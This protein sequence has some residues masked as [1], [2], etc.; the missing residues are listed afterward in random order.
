M[1]DDHQEGF[2]IMENTQFSVAEIFQDGCVIQRDKKIKV[3]GTA[4][5]DNTINVSVVK[6]GATIVSGSTSADSEGNYLVVLDPVGAGTGY[7]LHIS[8]LKQHALHAKMTPQPRVMGSF[9]EEE[10]TINDVS[11]GD[12]WLAG[13]QSNME[14]YL[15]YDK[16]WEAT[17]KLPKNPNIHMYNV[18]QRAFEGHNTHNNRG[19][20]GYWFTDSDIEGLGMFSAP[21]YSFAREIQPTIDVPVA[22]IGCNW[23]GSTASAWVPESVLS[24]APLNKYFEEYEEQ[25]PDVSEEELKRLSMEGWS[26]E[27]DLAGWK[28]FEPLMYGR[29]RDWQLKF[30]EASEG[31]EPIPMGPYN[32][33]RPSGLYHTML[34]TLIPYSLKGV[35]WYQGESDCGGRAKTY[36]KL[37]GGLIN[38]WRKE[39]DDNFPFIIVQLAPFG[40]W[41]ACGNDDY[42]I[43]R[44]MQQKVADEVDDVYMA[45]IMDIG[46]YYDIHPK[47][48]MEVGRRLGLLARGHVYGEDILCDAPRAKK[49]GWDGSVITI[50]LDN[51]AG[52][53]IDGESDILITHDIDSVRP[54]KVEVKDDKI[55]LTPPAGFAE[56][57]GVSIGWADYAVIGIHNASGLSVAPFQIEI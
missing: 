13:G 47:E 56:P 40:K 9:G 53:R 54:K 32:L 3:Y 33:N 35:I 20:Y 51:A 49:A 57:D 16:D 48:K 50:E 22:I 27:D 36:D 5:P 55:I 42:R 14:F 18:P 23:G 39:W 7:S 12:I 25:K 19:G 44:Q 6:N 52:L 30:M 34:S 38:D 17:K 45:S 37:L 26:R 11:F 4:S 21:G 8:C 24:E 28:N 10:I 31:A 2:T 43:V 29:D 46:S 15:M 1:L 41:L